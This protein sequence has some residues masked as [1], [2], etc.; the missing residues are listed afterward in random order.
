MLF[1]TEAVLLQNSR[2]TWFAFHMEKADNAPVLG[3]HV[4]L[5]ICSKT[6]SA[7]IVCCRPPLKRDEKCKTKMR[8][9]EL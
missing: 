3:A 9:L 6:E 1:K 8:L 2:G 4:F 5:N 7:Q